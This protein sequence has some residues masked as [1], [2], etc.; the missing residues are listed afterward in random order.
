MRVTQDTRT[1]QPT[2]TY[3]SWVS[4]LCKNQPSLRGNNYNTPPDSHSQPWY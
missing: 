3:T 4:T 1:A 2:C